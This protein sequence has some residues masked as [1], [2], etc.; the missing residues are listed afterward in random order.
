MLL[1]GGRGAGGA[2]SSEENMF[3]NLPTMR[4]TPANERTEMFRRK[5][6]ACALVFDFNNQSSYV[7]EK[8]SKRT[9]LL[10]IVEYVTNTRN[11]FSEQIMQDVVQM[12][13]ANIFRTL[14]PLNNHAALIYDPEEDEP[15]LER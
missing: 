2:S 12:V 8:E 11:C 1:K 6:Q 10:E 7:R 14:P 15:T 13:A 5:L 4:D 9:T 3:A